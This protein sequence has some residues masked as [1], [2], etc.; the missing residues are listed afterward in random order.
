MSEVNTPFHVGEL[1]AQQRAGAGDI[2]T[3]AAPFIRDYMPDQHRAFYQAQP[4]LVVSSGDAEGRVWVTIIEGPDGFVRSPDPRMLT[5]A[6]KIDPQDPLAQTLRENADVG[7]VGI[8]LATRRRNRLSGRT[9][10]TDSGFAID[11]RQ[12]FGNCP[13]YISERNWWRVARTATA[14]S[15]MSDRLGPAQ[16]AR[17]RAAD[18]LFIGSGQHGA[19]DAASSGFDA[20]H[21]GGEPGFVRVI[22]PTRLRIPDYSGNN[23]FNTIGNLLADSR[24]GLL[25]VDFATG[26][27]MHLTGRAKIDWAPEEARDPSILR[28][29]DVTIDSVIDR[30]DALSLR[31]SEKPTLSTKLVVADKVVEAESITSFHLAPAAG[32]TLIP[33]RAGQHLPIALDI[34]GHDAK[35]RR[36]YSLSGSA[37]GDRYRITVKREPDGAASRF[38]HDMVKVGDVIEV[39]APAGGFLIPSGDSPLVLVSVGVGLTPMLAMLHQ[40]AGEQSDRPVWFIHGARNGRHHALGDEVN[41]LIAAS[42]HA[43]KRVFFSMPE[44]TDLL[45]R[46]FDAEGRI[47]ADDLLAL[48]AGT[49][50]H[51]MLCGP[52]GFI[53]DLKSGLEAASVRTNQVHFESFRSTG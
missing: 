35:V 28:M 6:T 19:Q 41:R 30:R 43:T 36:S 45:G 40:T 15:V 34:P 50:A 3:R 18:T 25:F 38:L 10:R 16:I 52:V 5:V 27:L 51:Y 23:F 48:N 17:I 14:E 53:A 4:F 49:D 7:M 9:R 20:S 32:N 31:W 13:Q 42:Q 8:E 12:T 26:G 44:S 21:R 39:K 11:V 29:I 22:S 1:A 24:I 33:F 2:A 47:T 37:S 46:D